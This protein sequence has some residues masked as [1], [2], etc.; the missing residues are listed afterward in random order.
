MEST[1]LYEINGYIGTY[2][3]CPDCF[4]GEIEMAPEGTHM[5]RTRFILEIPKGWTKGRD[6]SKVYFQRTE[7]DE[8]MRQHE[9]YLD[10]SIWEKMGSPET[11]T[12]SV[13]PGDTLNEEVEDGSVQQ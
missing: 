5:T 6:A 1:T 8:D 3:E 11:I 2:F 9:M 10:K 12:V 4:K 7:A 13:E